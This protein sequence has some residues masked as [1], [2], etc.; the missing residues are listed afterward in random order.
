MCGL[1]HRL[2]EIC[3]RGA[4]IDDH[5]H[6]CGEKP[7]GIENA[8]DTADLCFSLCKIQLSC[9]RRCRCTE[10][11]TCIFN[12]FDRHRV[13]VESGFDNQPRT[14]CYTILSICGEYIVT[15]RFSGPEARKYSAAFAA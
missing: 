10:L 5:E 6:R 1:Q 3:L 13:A 15:I 4:I 2:C 9:H 11:A 12:N 7:T 14:A 8:A